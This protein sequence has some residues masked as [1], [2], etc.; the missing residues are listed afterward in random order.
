[1]RRFTHDYARL[2]PSCSGFFVSPFQR[3]SASRTNAI[4]TLC[5]SSWATKIAASPAEAWESGIPPRSMRFELAQETCE[6]AEPPYCSKAVALHSHSALTFESLSQSASQTSTRISTRQLS[7][8]K[9]PT[10]SHQWSF[11]RGFG[12]R[13]SR[14]RLCRV[15]DEGSFPQGCSAKGQRGIAHPSSLLEHE[16]AAFAFPLVWV[17]C[18]CLEMEVESA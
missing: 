18:I 7:N 16:Y 9:P 1:M 11:A 5:A 13:T 4:R 10:S 8:Q 14:A 17:A 3:V 15:R 2:P 12:P 6:R